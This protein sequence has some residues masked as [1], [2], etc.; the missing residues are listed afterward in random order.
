MVLHGFLIR[1]IGVFPLLD[2]GE[3]FC[4]MKEQPS[5]QPSSRIL[6]RFHRGRPPTFF[7]LVY[8]ASF[9]QLLTF[10]INGKKILRKIGSGLDAPII[11]T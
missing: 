10:K 1:V 2:I 8:F 4:G 6:L 7:C 11:R 3:L 5:A 9:G